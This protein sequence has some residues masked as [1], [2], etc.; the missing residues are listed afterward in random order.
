MLKKGRFNTAL[1]LLRNGA[2]VIATTRFVNDATTRYSK[3]LSLFSL[4]SFLLLIVLQEPDFDMWKGKLMIYR[5]N[6]LD[7]LSITEFVEEISTFGRLDVLI[8][9]AAQT[10]YRFF[11]FF[12][13]FFFFWWIFEY[14]NMV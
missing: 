2:T 4:P 5:L 9:N 14:I 7:S 8:N 3:V 13:F 6:L 12:L 1:K 10:I 11:V